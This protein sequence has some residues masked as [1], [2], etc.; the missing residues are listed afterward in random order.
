MTVAVIKVGIRGPSGASYN[1]SGIQDALAALTARVAALEDGA[2]PIVTPDAPSVVVAPS[3]SPSSV[4]VGEEITLTLGEWSDATGVTGVLTQDGADRTA[5]IVAG[6]WTPA[7]SGGWTWTVT[8]TGAGGSTTHPA[9]E[10]AVSDPIAPVVRLLSG[11]T[12]PAQPQAS[13]V[14]M[15]AAAPGEFN[16]ATGWSSHTGLTID[17]ASGLAKWAGTNGTQQNFQI[18]MTGAVATDRQY[19]MVTRLLNRTAGQVTPAMGGG[20]FTNAQFSI[21]ANR[22]AQRRIVPTAAHNVARLV[23]A[24]GTAAD[25]DYLRVYDLTTLLAKK[26]RIVF[27]YSQSNWVGNEIASGEG[28]AQGVDWSIDTPEP[29][30]IYFPSIANTTFGSEMDAVGLGK[31][32]IAL[33]PMQHQTENVGGGPGAAF[34]RAFA[35]GLRDDEVLV[36]LATGYAGGAR[37]P[38]DGVWNRQN[39]GVA[40]AGMI[41]QIDG[42][43]AKAPAGSTVA[44][45]IF[46]QGESD[47]GQHVDHTAA[48]RADLEYLRGRYGNMPIVVAE[49]GAETSDANTAAMIAEQAKLDMDS[50]N[51]LA[52]PNCRYIARRGN[53]ALMADKIHY[54]QPSQRARGADAAA[55][56]M[57]MLY[58]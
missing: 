5:E 39:N 49:I 24:G 23:V 2:P 32:M 56:L 9:I 19:S 53:A 55:A 48:V 54:D 31:P 13:P 22:A 58:A 42:A 57:G 28:T 36:Y 16:A 37:L 45:M 26:W 46:C 21:M 18:N 11:D 27:V 1:D 10:G 12:Y 30:A 51:A 7:Q 44:G 15:I 41:K 8:A 6:V 4:V 52:L 40:W 25:I 35:D 29:R 33:D 20:G 3:A 50:G 14:S 38:T 43:L 17:T 47:R 34:C